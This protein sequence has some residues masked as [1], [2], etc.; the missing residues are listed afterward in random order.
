MSTESTRASGTSVHDRQRDRAE[1]GVRTRDAMAALRND[2]PSPPRRRRP[3]MVALSILLII[4]GAAIAGLLA[5]NLDSREPVLVLAQDV[6]AGTEITTDLLRTTPVAS[7]GLQLVP[8]DQA[9]EVLGT[10]TRVPVSQGQLLDVTMLTTAEPMGEGRA[11]V[12]V[13]MTAGLVPPGLR[14]GDEVRLVRTGTSAGDQV[15]PLAIGLV[16]S[17]SAEEGGGLTGGEGGDGSATV[18]VDADSADAVVDAAGSNLLGIALVR[19]GVAID[20]ADLR[21]LGDG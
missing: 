18:L 12:G 10:Y 6:P 17:T 4:G 3:A 11:Q 5:L 9:A 15:T 14:S 2:R 13:P 16:L 19:R 7:E 20:D 21:A 1:R 8:E